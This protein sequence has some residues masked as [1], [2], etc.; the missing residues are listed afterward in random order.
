MAIREPIPLAKRH[1]ETIRTALESKRR[2]RTDPTPTVMAM[3][4]ECVLATEKGILRQK[5]SDDTSPSLR[6]YEWT[7]VQYCLAKAFL[8][9]KERKYYVLWR[10]VGSRLRKHHVWGPW[11]VLH[12]TREEREQILKDLRTNQHRLDRQV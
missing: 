4:E 6:V 2:A 1:I 3:T 9:T 12:E 10:W 5:F 8:Q 11:L 7:T